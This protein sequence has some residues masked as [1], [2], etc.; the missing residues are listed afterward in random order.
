MS[1]FKYHCVRCETE[2]GTDSNYGPDGWRAVVLVEDE[3]DL[4]PRCVASLEDWLNGET[5]AALAE[6]NRV[7]YRAAVRAAA[8]LARLAAHEALAKTIEALPGGGSSGGSL[9]KENPTDG[10]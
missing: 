4:C 9:T 5:D 6:A 10:E 1:R 8:G 2:V 3:V 7:G